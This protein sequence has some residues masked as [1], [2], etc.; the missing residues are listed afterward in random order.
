M[1]LVRFARGVS[2]AGLL[3]ASL[4]A[5]PSLDW[6]PIAAWAAEACRTPPEGAAVAGEPDVSD[7]TRAACDAVAGRCGAPAPYPC[8]REPDPIPF[9][10]NVWCIR[11]PVTALTARVDELPGPRPSTPPAVL[12]QAEDVAPPAPLERARFGPEPGPPVL[13]A[14][15]APPQ[16][17]APPLG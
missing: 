1:T 8:D 2:L 10:D 7:G 3:A 5:L 6:C 13:R 15:H 17:R 4:A 9:G 16:A 14:P 11:P 12:V